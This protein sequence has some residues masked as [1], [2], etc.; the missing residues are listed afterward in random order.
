MFRP[1]CFYPT[2]YPCIL[3]FYP[4]IYPEATCYKTSNT[5]VYTKIYP[6]YPVKLTY[7]VV[8]F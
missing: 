6:V 2:I 1:P 8:Y 5:N 4:T 3:G 7:H